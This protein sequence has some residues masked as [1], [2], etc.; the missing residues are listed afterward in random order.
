VFLHNPAETFEEVIVQNSNPSKRWLKF[1]IGLSQELVDR[2]LKRVSGLDGGA[3]WLCA[4][5]SIVE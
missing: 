3:G 1:D 4:K 2:Q 5:L